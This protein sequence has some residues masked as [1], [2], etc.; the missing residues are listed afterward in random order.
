[1]N[2]VKLTPSIKFQYWNNN[3]PSK[4]KQYNKFNNKNLF[5]INNEFLRTSIETETITE[6][7]LDLDNKL[8][9]D[10]IDAAL[11]INEILKQNNIKASFYYSGG[12][13]LHIHFLVELNQKVSID[14]RK[15][16]KVAYLKH[17]KIDNLTDHAPLSPKTLL[18][19]EGY[20]KRKTVTGYKKIYI[21]METMFNINQINDFINENNKKIIIDFNFFD[22][23]NKIKFVFEENKR[24]EPTKKNYINK[25]TKNKKSVLELPYMV[26]VVPNNIYIDVFSYLSKKYNVTSEYRYSI[27]IYM[28]FLNLKYSRSTIENYLNLI[29]NRLNKR[30]DI[31][32]VRDSV[33]KLNSNYYTYLKKTNL[34]F[35]YANIKQTLRLFGVDK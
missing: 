27:F 17:L 1:M 2:C 19:C 23:I 33:S 7:R 10:N 20:E 13:G 8:I 24:L 12:K 3:I 4:W 30:Y 28:Y 18:T 21:D 6:F 29:Y 5:I 25:S 34:N 35:N 26:Q 14:N 32:A 31:I 11:E 16:F 22:K 9:D 15:K